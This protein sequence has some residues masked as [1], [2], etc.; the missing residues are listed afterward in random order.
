MWSRYYIMLF[1]VA[2]KSYEEFGIVSIVNF[3]DIW[4][5]DFD[6]LF[7][8]YILKLINKYIW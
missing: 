5:Y 6:E 3:C 1:N 2:M 4:E 8:E 7:K